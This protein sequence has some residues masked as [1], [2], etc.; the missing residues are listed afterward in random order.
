MVEYS[1]IN[2]GSQPTGLPLTQY[3]KIPRLF[4]D[5]SPDLGL[6]QFSLANQITNN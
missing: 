4:P 6:F 1:K 3:V 5:F 2:C